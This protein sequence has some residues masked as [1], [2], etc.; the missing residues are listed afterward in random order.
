VP[1]SPLGGTSCTS[2]RADVELAEADAMDVTLMY[3]DGCPHWRITDDRLR[4]LQEAIGFSLRHVQVDTPE[5]AERR[6]FRGSPTVLVDGVDPFAEDDAPSGLVC[7]L[8]ATPDGPQG[9]PTLEQLHAI[10]A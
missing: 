8:Y 2:A 10:L 1:G 3:F 9:S 5:E 7:R 4:R 6:G